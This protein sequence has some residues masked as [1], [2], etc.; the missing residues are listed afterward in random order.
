MSLSR[1]TRAI[2]GL[3]LAAACL[4]L[5]AVPAL[6]R[7]AAAHSVQT[8]AP[9]ISSITISGFPKPATPTIK[10]TGTGFGSRPT[11][12]VPA[13]LLSN[14]KTPLK[15][16]GLDYGTSGLWL[17][18]GSAAAG[19]HGAFQFGANF[20]SSVGDC[21]GVTIESWTGTKV[22]FTLGFAYQQQRPG[23]TAGNTVCVSVK[24]VPGCLKLR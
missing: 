19:L 2:L 1:T 5:L 22:V 13:S 17:L 6:A 20:T 8:A 16:T 21:G 14:C 10:V 12:G 23:L 11:N 7:P 4:G 15:P 24:G 3:A 18:D 9:A